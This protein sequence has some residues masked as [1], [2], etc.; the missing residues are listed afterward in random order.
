M[1]IDVKFTKGNVLDGNCKLENKIKEQLI[2][3]GYIV[4]D[5]YNQ[6]DAKFILNLLDNNTITDFEYNTLYHVCYLLNSMRCKYGIVNSVGIDETDGTASSSLIVIEDLGEPDP[7]HGLD[8]QFVNVC[9]VG[10]YD[11][12]ANRRYIQINIQTNCDYDKV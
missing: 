4:K 1:N 2:D 10:Y 7:E 12:P 3:D 8:Y 6:V 5:E 11:Y 9:T